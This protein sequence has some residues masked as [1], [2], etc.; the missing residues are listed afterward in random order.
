MTVNTGG[1]TEPITVTTLRKESEGELKHE[2]LG[3]QVIQGLSCKGIRVTRTI[4]AGAIGNEQ[5]IQ[6]VDEI[7]RSPELST[8]VLSKH[9]DPRTGET[10]YQLT[11]VKRD[12]PDPSL[13]QVPADYKVIN[14]DTVTE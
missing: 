8:I 5:P 13:F 10:T 14:K 4:A 9:S 6:I 11:D 2:D 12:E 3:T 1:G 7:W